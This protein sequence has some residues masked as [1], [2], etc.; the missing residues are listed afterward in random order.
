MRRVGTSSPVRPSLATLLLALQLL[1]HGPGTTRAQE[2]LC[3]LCRDNVEATVT[4][5]ICQ[6]LAGA[7][8]LLTNDTYSEDI[9]AGIQYRGVTAGC[10][11]EPASFCNLCENG[12]RLPEPDRKVNILTCS[13]MGGV[14]SFSPNATCAIYQA[15]YGV[16]CGCVNPLASENACRICGDDVPLEHRTL[17]PAPE[18]Q[19]TAAAP[20]KRFCG[21]LEFFA[22]F[23][24]DPL[25]GCAD[26]QAE[27]GVSCCGG[28]GGGGGDDG[29]TEA[30][31]G[32]VAARPTLAPVTAPSGTAPI[33]ASAGNVTTKAPAAAPS[34]NGTTPVTPTGTS[35]LAPAPVATPVATTGAAPFPGTALTPPASA[36]T[37]GRHTWAVGTIV[38]ALVGWTMLVN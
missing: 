38:T 27:F 4:T 13:Q 18:F 22:Q 31:G 19:N 5:T 33:T 23:T 34:T 25:P 10:C 6:T 2:A 7:A 37:T 28:G 29:S 12:E 17:V 11:D 3:P 26:Y 35:P 24:T 8:D 1:A 30:P 36:A 16:Y 9:C 21:A 32:S 20:A 15:T 14:A